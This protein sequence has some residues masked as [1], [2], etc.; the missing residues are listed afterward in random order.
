MKRAGGERLFPSLNYLL[1]YR[2]PTNAKYR[3][4]TSFYGF[5][6]KIVISEPAFRN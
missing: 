3:N 1:S 4:G 6:M 5:S 2:T